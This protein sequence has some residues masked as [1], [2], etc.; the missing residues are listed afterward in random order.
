MATVCLHNFLRTVNN[1]GQADTDYCPAN[2]I[3]TELPNGQLVPGQWRN[4][5]S[6]QSMLPLRPTLAHRATIEAY[7]QRDA[8]ADYLLTPAGEVSWQNEYV[9]RGLNRTNFP[10]TSENR[11]RNNRNNN[12]KK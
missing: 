1:E 6:E 8:I 11:A 7:R 9:Q 4:D 12:N 3:D 2:F 10:E 5:Q